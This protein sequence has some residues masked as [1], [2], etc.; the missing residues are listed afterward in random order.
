MKPTIVLEAIR[1]FAACL[2]FCFFLIRNSNIFL[3]RAHKPRF[4]VALG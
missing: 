2:R 1:I 4:G 3:E